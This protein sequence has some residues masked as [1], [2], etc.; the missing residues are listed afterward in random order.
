[1]DN[2]KEGKT[3]K[4]C[5]QNKYGNT[6]ERIYCENIK[7]ILENIRHGYYKDQ[8]GIKCKTEEIK[9]MNGVKI[10]IVLQKPGDWRRDVWNYKVYY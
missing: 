1:M 6:W 4:T 2:L 5:Y 10:K 7:N 8:F 3:P 9:D